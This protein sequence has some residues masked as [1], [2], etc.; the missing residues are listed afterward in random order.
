M[1][2]PDAQDNSIRN[3]ILNGTCR[4]PHD[5][6]GMHVENGRIVVRVYDPAA[7]AVSVIAGKKRYPMCLLDDAGLFVCY[8]GT[9]KE[10]FAYK[11]EKQYEDSVFT[12][13]DPYCFLPTL[14]E[15]DI[16]LFNQ[17]EHQRAGV[18]FSASCSS[19]P[20]TVRRSSGANSATRGAISRA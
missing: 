13:E 6:L 11:I 18:F 2:T 3:D 7:K 14:G 10:T 12:S 15:M 19:S 9:K 5:Y 8:F 1:K 4:S 17:G 16:Y 20:M